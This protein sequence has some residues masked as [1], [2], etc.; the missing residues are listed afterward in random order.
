M[1]NVHYLQNYII[2]KNES[3]KK[4]ILKTVCVNGGIAVDLFLKLYLVVLISEIKM[5]C[6]R[7]RLGA[8]APCL[9]GINMVL[10]LLNEHEDISFLFQNLSSYNIN[11]QK[12][13][14]EKISVQVLFQWTL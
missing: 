3:I 9:L 11:N 12:A 2:P 10:L 13:K 6:P 7:F 14:F 1:G 5:R 4:S 8:T